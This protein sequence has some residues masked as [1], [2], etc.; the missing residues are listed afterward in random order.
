MIIPAL[1]AYG[2]EIQEPRYLLVLIPIFSVV[3]VYGL[4]KFRLFSNNFWI[5]I[6]FIGIILASVLFFVVY[7]R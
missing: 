2:R 1:Y 5:I 3:S 7:T 6:F 4:N